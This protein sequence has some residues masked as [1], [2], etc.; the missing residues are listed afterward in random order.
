MA[1]TNEHDAY[2]V[3]KRIIAPQDIG[4]MLL[5]GSEKPV[6]VELTLWSELARPQGPTGVAE[7]SCHAPRG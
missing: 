4:S 6:G 3:A 7:N 5:C 1:L 2:H